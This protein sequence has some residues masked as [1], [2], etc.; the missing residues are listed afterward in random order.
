MTTASHLKT[1]G[2][3]LPRHRH[4]RRVD[5]PTTGERLLAWFL[6]LSLLAMAA[7]AYGI[8]DNRW[9]KVLAV[10]GGSM[11]PT[12]NRGDLMVITRPGTVEVG[13]IAV[14]QVDGRLVTHRVVDIEAD[15]T[16]VTQ[17]DANPAPDRWDGAAI[18][19]VGVYRFRIPLLG[20]LLSSGVGAWFVDSDTLGVSVASASAP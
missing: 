3:H 2:R 7:V 15:G 12:I 5:A 13:D 17:G 16:L 11:E 19:V 20:H 18:E 6:I 1:R 14:F 10:D 4:L 8:M 9:Y